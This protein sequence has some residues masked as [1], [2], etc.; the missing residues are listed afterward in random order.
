MEGVP[1]ASADLLVIVNEASGPAKRTSPTATTDVVL[2]GCVA[3]APIVVRSTDV[4]TRWA[5]PA[6]SVRATD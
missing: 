2:S 5:V 4:W 3:V 1:V 6:D